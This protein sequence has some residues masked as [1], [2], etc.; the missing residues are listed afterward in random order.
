MTSVGTVM[1]AQHPR[2]QSEK[3]ANIHLF[4]YLKKILSSPKRLAPFVH[5]C[6]KRNALQFFPLSQ[7]TGFF[8]A[9]G[10]VYPVAAVSKVQRGWQLLMIPTLTVTTEERI[11]AIPFVFLL[12]EKK[13]AYQC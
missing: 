1:A 3:R 5:T 2:N 8:F 11:F 9:S 10:I 7:W 13:D 6:N 4:F 12:T